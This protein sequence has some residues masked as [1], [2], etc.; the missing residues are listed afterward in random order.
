MAGAP[1]DVPGRLQ[2]RE[3]RLPRTD[4]ASKELT[5]QSRI[6][7]KCAHGHRDLQPAETRSQQTLVILKDHAVEAGNV[8]LKPIEEDRLLLDLVIREVRPACGQGD[9]DD[10]T[11]SLEMMGKEG[12]SDSGFTGYENEASRAEKE[13][14]T[15]KRAALYEKIQQIYMT[16]ELHPSTFSRART[17]TVRILQRP[18]STRS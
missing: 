16:A 11:T 18:D 9:D 10:P 3:L 1:L 4:F 12:G 8:D 2:E 5:A 15:T 13:P 14:N 6:P 17:S 7:K